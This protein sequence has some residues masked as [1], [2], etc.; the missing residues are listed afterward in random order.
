MSKR[1][2]FLLKAIEMGMSGDAILEYVDQFEGKTD[3]EKDKLAG[4][5][6]KELETHNK[7]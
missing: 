5:F 6:L 7:I 1:G 4:R 2:E 3:E